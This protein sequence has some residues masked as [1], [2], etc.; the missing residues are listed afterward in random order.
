[1]LAKPLLK[2]KPRRR[3]PVPSSVIRVA[4]NPDAQPPPH[5][6]DVALDISNNVSLLQFLKRIFGKSGLIADISAIDLNFL[7]VFVRK[8]NGPRR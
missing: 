8:K 1:M 2:I 6:L 7:E 5:A 3:L 4:P